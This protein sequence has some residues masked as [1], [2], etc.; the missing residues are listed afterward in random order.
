MWDEL[1][2]LRVYLADVVDRLFQLLMK[3]FGSKYLLCLFM[4]THCS[5]SRLSP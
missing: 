3:Q 1:F 5:D 4:Y 2:L